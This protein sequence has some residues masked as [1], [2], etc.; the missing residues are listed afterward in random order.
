MNTLTTPTQT[1]VDWYAKQNLS[2]LAKLQIDEISYGQYIMKHA[3]LIGKARE[4]ER[5]Q[6]EEAW[7]KN[8]EGH[9]LQSFEEYY[10][11]RYGKSK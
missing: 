5:E 11:Q 8:I 10:Q 9:V 6:I 7:E 1:A 4:M 2:L 3:E